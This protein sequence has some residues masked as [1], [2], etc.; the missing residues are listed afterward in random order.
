VVNK[1]GR[2]GGKQRGKR[3]RMFGLGGWMHVNIDNINLVKG[4][5]HDLCI[6]C[7]TI[8]VVGHHHHATPPGI[9]GVLLLIIITTRQ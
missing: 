1:E 4:M 9:S 7:M 6:A 3:R 8:I 2:Q 5:H